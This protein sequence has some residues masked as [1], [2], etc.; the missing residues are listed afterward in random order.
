MRTF[1]LVVAVVSLPFA[2]I[3]KDKP[4]KCP[5]GQGYC[6]GGTVCVPADFPCPNGKKPI[7]PK[8]KKG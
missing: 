1:I 3:A 8:P 5:P 6:P 7:M 2:A 4:M